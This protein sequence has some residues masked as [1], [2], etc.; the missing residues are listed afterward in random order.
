MKISMNVPAV[1]LFF[2]LFGLTP[3]LTP[4][5]RWPTNESEFAGLM[6]SVSNW[7]RWGPRDELGALNL[8]APQ[9]RKQAATE[10]RQGVPI[11]LS[12]KLSGNAGDERFQHQMLRTGD[13]EGS[14]G[15]ADSYSFRYHGY[16]ITHLDAL[17]HQFFDGRMYN[18]F[19]PKSVT[20][21]GAGR[22]AVLNMQQGIFTRGVLVD[23]PA[24]AGER[25]LDSRRAIYPE[26]LDKWEKQ[27]G[28]RIAS[29][30]AVLIRTGSWARAAAEGQWKV[31][32]GSAGLHASAMQWFRKRDV[33]A[34][35]SDLALDVLP[36]R[37][38]G[39]SMPV[40]LLAI[41]A[42]GAPVLDNLDLEALSDAAKKR[43]RWTFLLTV[44]PLAVDG[45]TGSPVN[46]I[47]YF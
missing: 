29:G 23:L 35:G 19:S 30:D 10:V 47:A 27:T 41:I 1:I 34:F 21:K 37:V 14:T 33:A 32:A 20:A 16:T 17:C 26:D 40:H 2:G 46:P 12:R 13:Q 24:L 3:A 11:S 44:A 7:G 25:Y 22:L 8:I 31:E 43:G 18:D 28:V 6:K 39:I 36:S 42:M 4:A 5:D 38:A 9:K 15:S 45:G